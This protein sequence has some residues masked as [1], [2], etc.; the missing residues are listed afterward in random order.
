[1]T[2]IATAIISVAPPA[3]V[4]TPTIA[5]EPANLTLPILPRVAPYPFIILNLQNVALD[6]RSCRRNAY[7]RSPGGGHSRDRGGDSDRK[8]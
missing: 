7:R 6:D 1:V 3:V 8:Y 2:A 5:I 4:P